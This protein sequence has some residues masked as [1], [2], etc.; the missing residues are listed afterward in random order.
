MMT[1][2]RIE[3]RMKTPGRIEM[4][5]KT[6]GRIAMNEEVCERP[7]KCWQDEPNRRLWI[8]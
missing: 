5:M 1:F 4:R 8:E 2:G 6:P 7:Q 3:M